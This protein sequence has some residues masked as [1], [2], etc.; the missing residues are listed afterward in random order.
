MPH[1][2]TSWRQPSRASWP[3]FR[4]ATRQPRRSGE[5]CREPV[6]NGAGSVPEKLRPG[7]GLPQKQAVRSAYFC[8]LGM[9]KRVGLT[10]QANH[11]AVMPFRRSCRRARGEWRRLGAR[12]ASPRV[13]PPTK[14]G[15]ARRTLLLRAWHARISASPISTPRLQHITC[16]SGLDRENTRSC[17][18]RETRPGSILHAN[19]APGPIASADGWDQPLSQ[20]SPISTPRIKHHCGS[21]ID[22]EQ[23]S[24]LRKRNSA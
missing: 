22:R 8:V 12:K 3:D 14:A 24:A 6:A 20:I 16:G 5:C 15:R 19:R 2:S 4:P 21:G 10:S 13:G 11:E 1:D 9:R 7:S 18:H 17:L 23:R